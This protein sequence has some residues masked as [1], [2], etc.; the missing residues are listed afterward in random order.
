VGSTAV[1]SDVPPPCVS[2]CAKPAP[3]AKATLMADTN[4]RRCGNDMEERAEKDLDMNN[5]Q[6][7]VNENRYY[8]QNH[9]HVK[10]NDNYYQ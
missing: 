1:L 8:L 9:D 4:T 5:P 2:A 7:N 10:P 6:S 3:V